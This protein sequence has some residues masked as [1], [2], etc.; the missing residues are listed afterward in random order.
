VPAQ[1]L[2]VKAVVTPILIGGASL[3]GRR[4]GHE[5]GGW[6]VALPLTSGPVAFF[7]ATDQGASFAASAAVGM[8]AA[9]ASQVAFALAYGWSSRRGALPA[10]L[11]AF[12]AFAA[13]TV[14]LSFLHWAAIAIFVLVLGSLAVGY[15]VT[16]RRRKTDPAREPTQLPRWDIPVR[17]LAATAVV[18]VITTLAPVLGSHLAGLLS[19]FPVFAAVLAL[20]T[21]HRHGPS[22]ATSTLDGLVLGLLAPA[23]FFLVLSLTL[24]TVGLLAFVFAAAAAFAAQ[25]VTLVAIP[26]AQQPP[27]A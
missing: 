12:A 24:A 5:I 14:A 13:A 19:P 15:A 11:C 4:F 21:H 10:F 16:R 2:A 1:N 18:V 27:A 20:F 9:T 8:L 6:L 7:L 23:V 3:A 17:M 25:A 26:R 22:G